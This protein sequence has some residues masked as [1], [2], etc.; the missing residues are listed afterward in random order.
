MIDKDNNI[1]VLGYGHGKLFFKDLDEGV[2]IYDNHFIYGISSE[3]KSLTIDVD[4][5]SLIKY[6]MTFNLTKDN[7]FL[8]TCR[9]ADHSMIKIDKH[10]KQIWSRSYKSHTPSCCTSVVQTTLADISPEGDIYVSGASEIGKN[11]Y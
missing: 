7:N 9:S 10:F 4:T 3:G 6:P 1:F 8:I 5:N 11:T 2:D